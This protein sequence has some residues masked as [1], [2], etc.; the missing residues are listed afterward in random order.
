MLV[1]N[2]C[3]QGKFTEANS[4]DCDSKMCI[5]FGVVKM[6]TKRVNATMKAGQDIK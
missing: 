1:K 5:S 2:D 3:W 4:K 6:M